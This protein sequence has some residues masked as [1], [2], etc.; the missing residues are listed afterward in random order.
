MIINKEHLTLAEVKSYIKNLEEKKTL[1]EYLKKFSEITK[2]KSLKLKEEIRALN[3]PKIKEEHIVKVVDLLP[4]DSE[5]VNK[6]FVDV[7]LTE[8]EINAIL[9][10]TKGY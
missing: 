1:D 10:I 5:D 7:S 9:N 4:H 2:E 6:I 3:N 8:E